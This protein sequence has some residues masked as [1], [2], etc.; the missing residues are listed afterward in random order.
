MT[1]FTSRYNIQELQNEAIYL[2]NTQMGIEN[3]KELQYY[4]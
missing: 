3:Y 2:A 4:I 1:Y